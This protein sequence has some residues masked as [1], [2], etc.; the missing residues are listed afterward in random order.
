NS[1]GTSGNSGTITAAT[2]SK[3]GVSSPTVSNVG[4]TS[5]TLGATVASDGGT[6]VT[7]R[8]TVW[9]TAA[10]PTGNAL[11][12]GGTGTGAFTHNRTGLPAGTLVCFRGYAV[13]AVGTSYSPDQF[14]WTIPA[15]PAAAAA[16]AISGAGFSANWSA[17]TGATNYYL[18]VSTSSSFSSYV[19]G[20][21]NLSVGNVTSRSIIGLADG[22]TYYYRVRAQ[23]SGGTSGNSGT[24]TVATW[25]KPGVGSPTVSGAGQTS[26][27]LGATVSSDGGSVVTSRGTVWGT[28]AN[29][30]GNAVA[31]G[32]TGTGAFTHSRT[33]LPA[34]TRIYFRGYAVNAVGTGYSPDGSFWTVPA[35]PTATAATF[36]S[37]TGFSATW[38]AVAGATEYYLDV[39]VSSDFAVYNILSGYNNKPVGNVTSH[40]VTVPSSYGMPYYYR[41]RAHNSAGTSG[42]SGTI[43]AIPLSFPRLNTPTVS[44]IST[45]GAVL[46]ADLFDAGNSPV[47]ARGTVWST[48][49]NPTGNVLA[50]PGTGTGA[51]SHPRTGMPPGAFIYFRGYAVNSAGTNYSAGGNFWTLPLPPVL[52]AP[53]NVTM[54]GFQFSWNASTGAQRYLLDVST[55]SSFGTYVTGY[56]AKPVGQSYPTVAVTGL[57]EGVTYHYRLR[58]ENVSGASDYSTTGSVT[59]LS[60][61]VVALPVFSSVTQTSAVLGA[62]VIRAGN[63][64]ALTSRGTVWGYEP[65]PT[66]QWLPEYGTVTGSFTHARTGMLPGMQ[67]HFRGYAIN[68]AGTAYSEEDTFWTAPPNPTVV[69]PVYATVTDTSFEA[70]WL[71]AQ[72]ATHYWLD[73]SETTNFVDFVPGYQS[74]PVGNQ[75]VALVTNLQPRTRYYYRVRAENGGGISGYSDYYVAITSGRLELSAPTATD[76]GQ[77]SATLGATVTDVGRSPLTERGTV[78]GTSPSPEGNALAEGGTDTGAFSH[79]RTDLPAG[80]RIYFRGYAASAMG[81][82]YSPDGTFWTLP[83]N[84]SAYGASEVRRNS[85]IAQWGPATGAT[86]YL[87]DVSTQNSFGSFVPGYQSRSMESATVGTVTGLQENVFYYFRVRAQNSGGISGYSGTIPVQTL[88][89]LRVVSPTASNVGQ[90]SATLGA[91]LYDAEA[92][93]IVA[94]GTVWGTSPNPTGNVL[95]APG[96]GMGSFSH[97]RTN[98]PAGTLIYYRGYAARAAGT[99]YSPDGSFWTLPP[100]PAVQA[101]TSVS[102]NGF[103]ANWGA[104]TGATNYFLDVSTSSSFGSYVSGYQNLS[105]GN[106][107]SRSVTGLS[108]GTTYYYRL[109]AQN[110]GGSSGYSA[111]ESV[112][113]TLPTVNVSGR[114]TDS[115]SGAGVAGVAIEF[116][117]GG[118]SATTDSQGYFTK[119]VLLGWSGTLQVSG[120]ASSAVPPMRTVSNLQTD[121]DGQHFVLGGIAWADAFSLYRKS[122]WVSN[123]LDQ[124][125]TDFQVEI[126]VEREPGMMDGFRDLRFTDRNGQSVPYWYE[127]TG[128]HNVASATFGGSAV[129]S[130]QQTGYAISASLDGVETGTGGW[131]VNNVIPATG[132]YRFAGDTL[133]D[134]IQIISG[135]GRTGYNPIV[136]DLYYSTEATPGLEGTWLPLEEL[137]IANSAAGSILT[138]T[139]SLEGEPDDVRLRFKPV[140]ATGIKIHVREANTANFVLTEF[141]VFEVENVTVWLKAPALAAAGNTE[142]LMYYGNS[143]AVYEGNGDNVFRFFDDFEDGVVSAEKWPSQA[144]VGTYLFETNGVLQVNRVAGANVHLM[145]HSFTTSDLPMIVESR[146]K[147][148]T[149]PTNGWIPLGL[150]LSSTRWVAFLEHAGSRLYGAANTFATYATKTLSDY[151]R[152]GIAFSGTSSCEMRAV[153]HEAPSESMTNALAYTPWDEEAYAIRL[154]DRYNWTT[155]Q[156]MNGQID[157]IWIREY[158]DIEPVASPSDEVERAEDLVT[159]VSVSGRVVNAISGA[160]AG[161]IEISLGNQGMSTVTAD[162]GEIGRAQ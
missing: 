24:I 41:V 161:G 67:I 127:R 51:F 54:S 6:P 95:P 31:Q 43:Q 34:G 66:N 154:V 70:Q 106:S 13:N 8:G 36:L 76:V 149:L 12:Q 47:T 155:A 46:G 139:V 124:V 147:T 115:G 136:Y 119:P 7:A 110:S 2:W 18:D 137:E 86:N 157:A 28:S 9:G 134:E 108:G 52:N 83:P 153:F 160:G 103:T 37:N 89:P 50:A 75:T 140:R 133:V 79:V 82:A 135:V 116:S 58:A 88:A 146:A 55:N 100:N 97:V 138:N 68:G 63:P 84:P 59:T 19:S 91:G 121:L 87:L 102:T 49:P 39:A 23:N 17:A 38:S 126:D 22:T 21:Q 25:A 96:T 122:I 105:V 74:R 101:A 125:L 56:Q 30:T 120:S 44:G 159:Y 109:C 104:A 123:A 16:S 78:W 3:P 150:W 162:G 94:R 1:G 114:V 57:F 81:T 53:S 85:F 152:L 45:T 145:S 48:S 132:V 35:N 80:T 32:G 60:R 113:F 14:F 4:Q 117:N 69:E 26:A 64:A 156:S 40:H 33:G 20:Y 99:V 141:K 130:V 10:S 151:H 90:T 62:T 111:V 92:D 131:A 129:A 128:I 144:G 29:P 118:G 61:P 107:T 15:N 77:T 142:L 148:V 42:H 11:A 71:A 98:L 93:E 65:N 112:Q 143:N 5:A 72:G 27:T 73:V 158:A